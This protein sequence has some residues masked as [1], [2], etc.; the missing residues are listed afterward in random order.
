MLEK[1]PPTIKEDHVL[2]V[3]ILFLT[4]SNI[5]P[6]IKGL[7]EK[8]LSKILSKPETLA[9]VFCSICISHTRVKG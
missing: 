8:Y 3:T 7:R 6:E 4:L 9:L 1:Y 5:T 2:K